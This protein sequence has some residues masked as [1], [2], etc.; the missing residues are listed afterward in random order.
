MKRILIA[1]SVVLHQLHAGEALGCGSTP[2][3]FEPLLPADTALDVPRD[4]ALFVAN[5]TTAPIE[6]VLVREIDDDGE[7]SA[8]PAIDA[9]APV[10]GERAGRPAPPRDDERPL[11]PLPPLPTDAGSGPSTDVA[12]AVPLD[13]SCYPAAGGNLCVAKPKVPLEPNTRYSWTATMSSPYDEIVGLIT[14]PMTFRT[15]DENAAVGSPK[16]SVEVTE[17][18][19]YV[20]HPCGLSSNVALSVSATNL[21]LPLL[22]NAK[23]LTP[24]FV[25]QPA[26]LTPEHT[27][28]EFGLY[29]PPECFVIEAFDTT[30][31][32]FDVGE[33]C[34]VA[35]PTDNA[36]DAPPAGSTPGGGGSNPTDAEPET[37]SDRESNTTDG[38]VSAAPPRGVEQRGVDSGSKGGC[39]VGARGAGREPH[40]AWL[41]VGFAMAGVGALRRRSRRR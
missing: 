24:A 23:R 3:M 16:V 41:V 29:D 33:V 20:N 22:V 30:G 38:D 15:G 5:N 7:T 17:H 10:I 14:S 13:V 28:Q 6:F 18:T 26:I 12:S 36:T 27:Q 35:E 40:F 8:G 1:A 21:T 37:S 25:V 19:V 32:R 31:E 4:A 34:S 39:A 9:G 2:L 11:M